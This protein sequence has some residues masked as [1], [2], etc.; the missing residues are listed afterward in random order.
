MCALVLW[1][2]WHPCGLCQLAVLSLGVDFGINNWELILALNTSPVFSTW[3]H[4]TQLKGCRYWRHSWDIERWRLMPNKRIHKK[5]DTHWNKWKR[6]CSAVVSELRAAHNSVQQ[7][8]LRQVSLPARVSGCKVVLVQKFPGNPDPRFGQV[9]LCA[10]RLSRV[11]LSHRS[12]PALPGATGPPSA[13]SEAPSPFIRARCVAFITWLSD[14]ERCGCL[15]YSV[16][17]GWPS[18]AT[19]AQIKHFRLCTQ[20]SG[21]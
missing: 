20:S 17:A 8:F 5:N 12:G 11:H 16:E 15:A 2:F 13:P 10:V 4:V 18:V 21:P 1:G 3:K 9:V 6:V 14:T 7:W 19:W